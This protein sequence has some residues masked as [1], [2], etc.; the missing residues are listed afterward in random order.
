M[1]YSCIH[2][3]LKIKENEENVQEFN[4]ILLQSVTAENARKNIICE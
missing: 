4:L 3:Y 2:F 1:I